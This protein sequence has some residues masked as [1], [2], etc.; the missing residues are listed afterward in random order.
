MPNIFH[1]T[2]C[3]YLT[4]I[5]ILNPILN[6]NDVL[7][8]LASFSGPWCCFLVVVF[9]VPLDCRH[10]WFSWEYFL[11]GCAHSGIHEVADRSF[12]CRSVFGL[13]LQLAGSL[14]PS[15]CS[16][17]LSSPNLFYAPL[18]GVPDQSTVAYSR[19]VE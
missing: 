19:L 11:I 10:W 9:L 8:H 5:L 18:V 13:C 7:F 4:L 2:G 3:F 6:L 17:W 12:T 16:G 15:I 1:F 14:T